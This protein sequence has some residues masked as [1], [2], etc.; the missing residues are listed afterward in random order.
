MWSK[1][2]NLTAKAA[3][4]LAAAIAF[5]S[6]CRTSN[7]S[8]LANNSAQKSVGGN[9]TGDDTQK[10]VRVPVPPELF[11][12]TPAGSTTPVVSSPKKQAAGFALDKPVTSKGVEAIITKCFNRDSKF[13]AQDWFFYA[14]LYLDGSPVQES[15]WA[16]VNGCNEM[17]LDL[18][19]LDK[20]KTY[21]VVASFFWEDPNGEKTIVW[22]EGS[23]GAFTPSDQS[24]PLVLEKL[25]VDQKVNVDVQKSPKDLCIN[26]LYL[27][28]GQRCLDTPHSI[29]FG[30]SDLSD[31][32]QKAGAS[33]DARR[34]MCLDFNLSGGAQAVQ[35]NCTYGPTQKFYLKLH[36]AVDLVEKSFP[37]L[38]YSWFMIEIGSKRSNTPYCL[39]VV[40]L[41]SGNSPVLAARPCDRNVPKKDQLFT[42]VETEEGDSGGRDSFRV[43]SLADQGIQ[44]C[45][46]IPPEDGD[47]T[48]AA[49]LRSGAQVKL[50]RCDTDSE[51]TR[52]S[53][54]LKFVLEND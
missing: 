24:I 14:A 27:W 41:P 47:P 31:Y 12:L 4:L 34:R 46:S 9:L 51:Y 11:N 2:E 35:K 42:L 13:I 30:Q 15:N 21:E 33:S 20:T 18:K 48:G 45:I 49:P 50:T 32:A 22:Y 3:V 52:R 10:S 25:R 23:T 19:I 40:T 5:A 6:G 8:Q 53:Q 43:V 38:Q 54:F 29:V 37:R 17:Q 36:S 39:Q 26:K 1:Y 7:K 44:R 16:D 28:N